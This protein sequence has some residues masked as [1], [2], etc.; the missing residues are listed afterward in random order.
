MQP[1]DN[2]YVTLSASTG[3]DQTIFVAVTP[4][5]W[6]RS[7]FTA[8]RSALAAEQRWLEHVAPDTAIHWVLARDGSLTGRI[9]TADGFRWL[10]DCSLPAR[11]SAA[12]LAKTKLSNPV[13]CF[14]SPFHAAA[15]RRN[16][17]ALQPE[18]AVILV[19]PQL[20]QLSTVLHCEDFSADIARH[21]LWIVAG[22]EWPQ[23][24]ERLLTEQIGLAVPSQFLRLSVTDPSLIGDMI[25]Q[26]QA[27]FGRVIAG[28]SER[29][30]AMQAGAC[31]KQQRHLCV[32]TS[33]RFRLWHDEGFTLSQSAPADAIRVDSSDPANGSPLK[34]A[35][36]AI[37][38]GILLT[39][40]L[41]RA[42]MPNVVPQHVPWLTWIT[43][44]RIPAFQGAAPD[45]HLLVADPIVERTAIEQGWPADR[46]CAAAWP[47]VDDHRSDGVG[48]LTVLSNTMPLDAP[49]ELES[50]S[51]HR[52]L[53]DTIRRDIAADPAGVMKLGV[54]GYL[55][56]QLERYKIATDSFP[57]ERFANDL[58]IPAY[59][60]AIVDAKLRQNIRVKLFGDGW[61]DI[62]RFR[63]YAAAP[64]SSRMAL[65]K[66]LAEARTLLHVWPTQ[67][68]HP[69]E[70][71]GIPVVRSNGSQKSGSDRKYRKQLHETLALVLA[72]L[73]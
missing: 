65:Q 12:M 48:E 13:T 2:R 18:Q 69:S 32:A 11:A 37:D 10:E 55:T 67:F 27:V 23:Q 38:A 9:E 46:V 34:M 72:T 5:E 43:N 53:W 4:D 52:V 35:R 71:L 14:L 44:D 1:S 40:N 42:D 63:P 59:A 7:N 16:L 56:R 49:K 6:A 26:A 73:A 58:I 41:A 54:S 33:M 25:N 57:F 28:R 64:L 62:A 17:D 61:S 29:I 3:P 50:F 66:A 45:D 68:V 21:R 70:S 36:C 60:Q 31:T 19:L 8:N 51:S 20:P 24:L 47:S 30:V 22:E 39:P 15:V